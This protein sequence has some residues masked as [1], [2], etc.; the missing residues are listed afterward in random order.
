M[1][2][3]F[4]LFENL[5]KNLQTI[6]D[7][8]NS[9][10]ITLGPTGKIGIASNKQGN[11]KIITTGSILLNSLEFSSNSSNILLKLLQQASSK[12]SLVSG[13][14]STTTILMACELLKLS[15]RFLGNGY[16]SIVLSNGFKK[17]SYF[18]LDKIIEFSTPIKNLEDLF[19]ILKTTLGKKV[20]K[21]LVV[22]VNQCLSQIGRDGLILVE[23]NISDRNEIELIQGIELDKGF[24]SSYFVTDLKNFQVIF[25][26][27]FILITN[28]SIDSINQIREIIEYIK[29]TNRPLVIIA[30]EI[31]KDIISTLVL[32]NLQK[33]L[34]V[35]V[36]KYKGIQFKKTGILEDLSLLTHSNY[37]VSNIKQENNVL[38]IND[39]GQAEKV[40]IG[41]NKSTFFISKFSKLLGERRINELNREL[42]IAESEYEKSLFKTRIARLSGH[43][44]KIKL[45]VSNKYEIEEQKQKIEN[46]LQTI[47]SSLEEGVVPGGGVFYFYLREEISNWAYLNL[48]GDE[49]ISSYIVMEAFLSPFQE[50]CKNTNNEN[51]RFSYQNILLEKGY[52]F[53][54]N[55]IENK[56]LNTLKEGLLDSS[57]A[58]R[59]ILWNSLSLVSTIIVSD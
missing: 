46:A 59:T 55:L 44:A 1:K 27:P 14:G 16:N 39:L 36:I 15:L 48:I 11:L 28:I 22:L 17:L 25:E 31:N 3:K 34:K 7:I 37:F 10:K 19:G 8:N 32:N 4:S 51:Q 42:L 5:E 35:V 9:I 26:K 20:S 57:K 18:I 53:G 58:V 49:I 2:K 43:I 33:K 41:K 45:G 54:Y 52:P 29:T 40:I 23:E 21:E 6:E 13:D 38:T 12:T 56:L 30:E 50:L 47:K 24:A